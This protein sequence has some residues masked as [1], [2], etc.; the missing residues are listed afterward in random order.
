MDMIEKRA[1]YNL[2]RMNWI[3]EPTLSVE[4]W[5]VE[6]YRQLPLSGLFSRLES[7]RIDLDRMSFVA[8][9]DECDSPEELTEYLIGSN[10]I[11]T[12]EEDQIY[13]LVFELWRRL[14]SEKPSL[15]VVCNEL[16][17]YI[18]LYDQ[19]Q[20]DNPLALQDALTHFIYALNENADQGVSPQEVMELISIHCAHDIKTFLYDFI[21]EQIAE[22]NEIYARE[23]LD[24][25]DL[26]LGKNKWFKLI[27]LRLCEPINGKIGRKIVGEI[28]EEHLKEDDLDYN[29][30]FLSMMIEM[31]D[32]VIFRLVA[33]MSFSLLKTEENFCDL[34]EIVIDYFQR[35]DEE[36][37]EE[38]AKSILLSRAVFS[39][40][41][42]LEEK[43]V[44][45]AALTKLF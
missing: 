25:F 43:D 11:S 1:L 29:L 14:M 35:I 45:L 18:Y 20:L 32:D 16:D 41:R 30:E 37:K 15:S 6:D 7:F 23:L 44:G 27:F 22:D 26:Y 5:Q 42:C 12:T 2:L 17:Y 33:K 8:F 4:L 9:A 21:C 3:N 39:M 40:D 13:L 38:I 10:E 36:K 34:L 24:H 31:G 19:Q 28:I